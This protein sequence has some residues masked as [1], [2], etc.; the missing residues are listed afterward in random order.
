MKYEWLEYFFLYGDVPEEILGY[1][2]IVDDDRGI[3]AQEQSNLS[4]IEKGQGIQQGRPYLLLSTF[5]HID[6]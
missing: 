2:E 5:L 1:V 6:L 3:L 4:Y